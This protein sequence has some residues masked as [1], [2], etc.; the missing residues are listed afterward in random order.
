MG[1]GQ[2]TRGPAVSETQDPEQLRQQ[3]EET[4]QELGDTVEALAA[5]TDVKAQ[6]KRKIAQRKTAAAEKK[7]ELLAKAKELSP[8]QASAAATGA[9]ETAKANPMPLATAGAFLGGVLIG[10]ITKRKGKRR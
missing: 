2:G 3:I 1:Q 9:T 4:R 7:D 6:A 8:E 10:R 5:K